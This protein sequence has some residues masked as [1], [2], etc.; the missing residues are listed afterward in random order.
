MQSITFKSHK[1]FLFFI[2]YLGELRSDLILSSFVIDF[3]LG[4]ALH[5]ILS[6]CVVFCV[7][8]LKTSQHLSYFFLA[9]LKTWLKLLFDRVQVGDLSLKVGFNFAL[10]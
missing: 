4:V 5:E 10:N 6:C 7:F 3:S 9:G 2:E 8:L 1:Q